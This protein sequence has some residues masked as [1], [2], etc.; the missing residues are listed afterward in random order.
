ML[1]LISVSVIDLHPYYYNPSQKSLL[2]GRS[3][4]R[5]E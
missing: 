2:V 3:A 5:E 1:S 4:K